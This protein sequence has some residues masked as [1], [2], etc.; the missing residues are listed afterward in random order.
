MDRT[1]AP[2]VAAIDV[3]ELLPIEEV[4]QQLRVIPERGLVE[5]SAREILYVYQGLHRQAESHF[6]NINTSLLS[7]VCS[8]EDLMFNLGFRKDYW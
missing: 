2:A 5:Q 8:L 1:A 4:L 3:L 7:P 6:G